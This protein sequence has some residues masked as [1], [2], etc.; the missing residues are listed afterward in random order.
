[1]AAQAPRDE[2]P[3]VFADAGERQ[4]ARLAPAARLRGV[5]LSWA[6]EQMVLAQES[7]PRAAEEEEPVSWS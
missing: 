3:L 1:V 2:L 5:R 4:D 7:R 6:A